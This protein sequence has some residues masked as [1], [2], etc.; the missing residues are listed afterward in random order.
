MNESAVRLILTP[1]DPAGIGPDICLEIAALPWPAAITVIGD[2]DVLQQRATETGL[3]VTVDTLA[4]EENETMHQRGRLQ[5]RPLHFPA[6]VRAGRPDPAN[7][8]GVVDSIRQATEA[9]LR[10]DADAIV[11]APVSKA[12]ICQSGLPFSGH[13]EFIAAA[14]GDDITPVMMLCTE[15]LRVA[16]ATTHVPLAQVPAAITPRRLESVLRVLH[17]D[18]AGQF[19]IADPH[20]L[21]CGLNPHAG[22]SGEL[23][24]EEI[25][26]ITPTLKNLRGEGMR[27]TGPL[28]ADTLFLPRNLA[29]ADAVLAM[30]HDQGL[31][32][33]KYSGFGTAVN[34]TLGLPFVRTSVDHGTAFDLA[35]SGKADAG[36]LAAA[37]ELAVRLARRRA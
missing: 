37:I 34:V 11:T 14:C 36:S 31:P 15:R 9:C 28:P 26:T 25:E 33:L 24:H 13:T 18:L 17:R 30:Y 3:R 7:A 5:V 2:P 19:D 6:A 12:V 32:V 35:G 4:A 21:V 22:E 27:L 1:G 10:G 16:L 8:A 20:I 23:G 29:E